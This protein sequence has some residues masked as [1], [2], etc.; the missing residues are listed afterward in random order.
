VSRCHVTVEVRSAGGEGVDLSLHVRAAAD[1]ASAAALVAT[2]GRLGMWLPSTPQDEPRPPAP[3]LD[4]APVEA[5][6]PSVKPGGNRLRGRQPPPGKLSMTA[7]AKLR[8]LNVGTVSAR[9]ANGNLAAAYDADGWLDVAEA[10]RLLL[11]RTNPDSAIG[12]A[13]RR[14]LAEQEQGPP[15][16][17][18]TPAEPEP[19]RQ[20]QP[21]PAAEE[22]AAPIVVT[23]AVEEA[24]PAPA[25][26]ANGHQPPQRPKAPPQPIEAVAETAARWLGAR[27]V[28]AKRP[29]PGVNPRW[30]RVGKDE[31]DAAALIEVAR[32]KGAVLPEVAA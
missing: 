30:W 6:R 18:E 32:A 16:P 26:G 22:Q 1:A 17:P 29:H 24:A 15:A 2:L 7:Y 20:E 3:E 21:A 31:M 10:D 9:T 4:P 11:A 14:A 13:L 8:G 28:L 19:E 25:P 23:A 5:A 12:A 27:G